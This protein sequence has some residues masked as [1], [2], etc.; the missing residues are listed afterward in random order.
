V[1]GPERFRTQ[2]SSSMLRAARRYLFSSAEE[3]LQFL[4]FD[5]PALW[6]LWFQ[7]GPTCYG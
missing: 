1:S 5:T 2:P 3:E 7:S 4:L 6:F